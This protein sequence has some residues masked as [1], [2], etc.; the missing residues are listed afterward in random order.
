MN[1][2]IVDKFRKLTASGVVE[3]LHF[4]IPI[5]IGL[6]VIMLIIHILHFGGPRESMAARAESEIL[7]FSLASSTT[8]NTRNTHRILSFS[9]SDSDLMTMSRAPNLLLNDAHISEYASVLEYVAR[10]NPRWIVL[11]WLTHAHPMT[12]EY[13]APITSLIDRLNIRDRTTIAI[14]FFA[15]GNINKNYAKRYNIVEAR[16]CYHEINLHCT[17]APEW[18]WM[19]Q[20]IFSRFLPSTES[21]LSTNLPHHLPNLVLNLPTISSIPN[22]NFMDTRDPVAGRI[23]SNAIVFIGNMAT[24]D[25]MFRDNKEVLQRTYTAQSEPRRSLQQDGTPWHIFWAGVTMMLTESRAINVAPRFVI[26][27]LAVLLGCLIFLLAFR[28]VDYW[29]F[30]IPILVVSLVLVI[31]FITIGKFYYYLPVTPILIAC[32][33]AIP[34]AIFVISTLNNYRKWKLLAMARRAEESGDLKQ[35]FLQLISHNLNTP[36]AQLKGLLE[37]LTINS[38]QNL[39]L[40]R[41]LNLVD[42]VRLAARSALATSAVSSRTLNPQRRSLR[43]LMEGFLDDEGSFFRRMN[44]EVVIREFNEGPQGGVWSKSVYLDSDLL[45]SCLLYAIVLHTSQNDCAQVLINAIVAPGT[46]DDPDVLH[47]SLQAIGDRDTATQIDPPPFLQETLNRYLNAVEHAN[48]ISFRI[49]E[50]EALLSFKSPSIIQIN[51]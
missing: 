37:I 46:N 2:T 40:N 15:S 1:K 31:N 36:I 17:Y 28:R 42:Y 3:W 24:Q 22:F 12:P 49:I 10:H 32:I 44:L 5:I 33:T 4:G 50:S 8:P 25:I 21:I 23:P 51:P 20:Q 13:L 6:F 27:G 38:P 30:V 9:V 34:A 48:L 7:R 41:A 43:S 39:S 26:Y 29:T 19:P 14:N 47:I 11:S 16:D 18:S 35:N 45:C